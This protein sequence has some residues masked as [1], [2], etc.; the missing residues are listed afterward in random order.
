MRSCRSGAA[1][2]GVLLLTAGGA[3]GE[4]RPEAGADSYRIYCAACHGGVGPG[5]RE[6]PGDAPDLTRLAERHGE[7]L[8]TTRLLE[9]IGRRNPAAAF[10]ERD[11][12]VCGTL[13][14]R[15]LEPTAGLR[16]GRRGT[17][18]AILQYLERVQRAPRAPAVATR[19]RTP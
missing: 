3:A 8:A 5:G 12:S 19:G 15:D 2:L 1:M 9:R 11:M 16:A 18:L 4:G 7:P 10:F 6:F 14:L 17:A 13:L